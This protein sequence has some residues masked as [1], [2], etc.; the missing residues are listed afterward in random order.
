MT[1]FKASAGKVNIILSLK[2][3]LKTKG[4]VGMAQ[5]LVQQAERPW[6]HSPILKK[7]LLPIIGL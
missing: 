4:T 1:T 5:L 6:V 3:N 2:S 7:N